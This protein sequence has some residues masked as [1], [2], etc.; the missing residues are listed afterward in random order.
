MRCVITLYALR[1]QICCV[2][3]VTCAVCSFRD[4]FASGPGAFAFPTKVETGEWV[5]GE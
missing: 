1:S 3:L 4:G 5:A 2:Q